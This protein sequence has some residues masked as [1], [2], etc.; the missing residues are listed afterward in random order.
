MSLANKLQG[1]VLIS[2][3]DITHERDVI[4]TGHLT[5]ITLHT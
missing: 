3:Y 5:R 1:V 4:T 2:G